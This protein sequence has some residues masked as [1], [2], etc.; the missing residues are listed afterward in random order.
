MFEIFVIL[1]MM[2]AIFAVIMTHSEQKHV[3]NRNLLLKALS[4]IAC[5]VWPATM[6]A[7]LVS[8]RFRTT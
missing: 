1:Y 5:A 3:G 2:I 7:I 6:A 8:M 4:F